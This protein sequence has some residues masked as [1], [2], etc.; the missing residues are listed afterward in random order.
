MDIALINTILNAGSIIAWLGVFYVWLGRGNIV[1]RRENTLTLAL[2]DQIIA[3][4]DETITE[5]RVQNRELLE[6]GQ[7]MR[8]FIKSAKAEQERRNA[9]GDS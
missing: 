7:L 6:V 9:G 4:K 1:T 5:L 3:T 8:D 2:K